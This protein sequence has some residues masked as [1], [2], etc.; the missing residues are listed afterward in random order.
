MN[1]FAGANQ[2]GVI[3]PTRLDTQP[4]FLSELLGADFEVLGGP[5]RAT[6]DKLSDS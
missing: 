3:Q 2:S 6:Q 5:R 4:P 1:L